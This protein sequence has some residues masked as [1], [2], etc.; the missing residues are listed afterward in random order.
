MVTGLFI[1]MKRKHLTKFNHYAIITIVVVATLF[2]EIKPSLRATTLEGGFN[3][4]SKY[5]YKIKKNCL[6][7]NKEFY[8]KPSIIKKGAGKFCSRKC[9]GIWYSKNNAGKN[10]WNWG[11]GKTKIKRICQICGKEFYVKQ[12][13][14]KFR[15]VIFCSIKCYGKQISQN[16]IGKNNPMWRGGITPINYKIRNSIEYKIWRKSIFKRDNFVCQ[17]C[18]Q[19]G[20]KLEAHHIKSFSKYPELRFEIFNGITL[21]EKCHKKIN[22]GRPI[23]KQRLRQEILL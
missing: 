17:K 5:F 20:G 9:Q 22:K 3:F 14:M 4:M 18:G 10:H 8:K 7:C 16:Q 19:I 11:T 2:M 21:C 15:K 1:F 23:A 13:V 12:S 6:V